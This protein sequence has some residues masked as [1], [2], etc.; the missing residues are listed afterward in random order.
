MCGGGTTFKEPGKAKFESLAAGK[1]HKPIPWA[2]KKE[3]SV[4]L[5]PQQRR[6]LISALVL[7]SH[8]RSAGG[9]KT[10]CYVKF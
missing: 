7:V 6:R 4:A 5:G 8:H 10:L 1:A 2:V 3:A 9:Q